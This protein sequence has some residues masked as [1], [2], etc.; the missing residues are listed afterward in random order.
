[1]KK[2][3]KCSGVIFIVINIRSSPAPPN[4]LSISDDNF[5][6]RYLNDAWAN[7]TDGL[8]RNI[9]CVA[10]GARPPAVLEWRI[11]DDVVFVLQDQYDVVRGNSYV[12]RKAVTITPSKNDEGKNLRCM[13]S[14]PV[15]QNRLQISIY[16]NAQGSHDYFSACPCS[17]QTNYISF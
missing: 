13:A 14:H 4:R 1:M 7:L 17:S 9:T 16:L 11:P 3:T 8:L 2:W 5:Q 10:Y 15:L 6:D 12:S